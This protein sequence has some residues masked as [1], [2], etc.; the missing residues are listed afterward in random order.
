MRARATIR[1]HNAAIIDA[2]KALG[3][4]VEQ[5]AKKAG[6]AVQYV[7][8][9]QRFGMP[10]TLTPPIIRLASILGLPIDDV[11]REDVAAAGPPVKITRD[12]QLDR[13]LAMKERAVLPSGEQAAE[14]AETADV[15]KAS[16]DE[17]TFRQR[18]ILKR[19]FGLDGG[20]PM[21]LEDT[22]KALLVTK[23]RVRQIE[24]RALKRLATGARGAKL[25]ETFG[26]DHHAEIIRRNGHL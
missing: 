11:W 9:L 4:T 22:A 8:I 17:L 25:A 23:E 21:S 2:R 14:S 1:F 24:A 12:F 15:L 26:D 6:V 13:L 5:L 3:L 19:R 10:K 16:L 20:T 7:Y 18:E